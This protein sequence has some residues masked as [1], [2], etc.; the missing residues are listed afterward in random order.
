MSSAPVTYPAKKLL[1]NLV[2]EAEGPMPSATLVRL[3]EIFGIEANNV[4]V[5]LNRLVSEELLV[6]SERGVYDLGPAARKLADL[7]DRWRLLED[8]LTVWDG[9]WLALYVAHLGRRDRK[10]LRQRERATE[11]WGFRSFEQGLL[12]RPANLAISPDDLLENL[13]QLGL[14]DNAVLI[15][16]A[17]F[18]GERV[19]DASLWPVDELTQAYRTLTEQMSVWLEDYPE[20]SLEDAA[21][22]CF[23]IGDRVLRAIAFDPRLPDSMVDTEARRTMVETMMLFDDVGNAIWSELIGQLEA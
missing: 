7:Q 14:E 13:C 19:P 22:E 2:K 9:R 20:N 23:L 1:L 21:R 5:S 6:V 15:Y 12:V 10:Q 11:L 3:A 4:R 16:P 18:V 17:G 8:E